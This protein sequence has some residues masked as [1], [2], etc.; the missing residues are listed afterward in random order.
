M[1]VSLD[2]VRYGH[3]PLDSVSRVPAR[4]TG[5][6]LSFFLSI[7]T[8][9][10]NFDIS[11]YFLQVSRPGF[12]Y[13]DNNVFRVKTDSQNCFLSICGLSFIIFI[14]CVSFSVQYIA[15]TVT[16]DKKSKYDKIAS[17]PSKTRVFVSKWTTT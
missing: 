15:S 4:V 8:E 6:Y 10:I 2:P 12:F 16:P 5:T 13:L 3:V 7:D 17:A 9:A 11:I 1:T 14:S